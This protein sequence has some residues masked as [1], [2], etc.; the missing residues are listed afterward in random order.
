MLI[1]ATRSKARRNLLANAGFGYHLRFSI[2]NADET[3]RRKETP[4]AHVR[5]LA[6]AK[7]MAILPRRNAIIIGVDTIVVLGKEI[8]GKPKNVSDARRILRKLSGRW[9]TV[10]SGLAVRDMARRTMRVRV[11]KTRV[12][13][14]KLSHQR[15]EWYVKTGEPF[16]K[17]G[18]YAVQGKGVAFID[19]IRGSITNVIGLPM[20]ILERLLR[21]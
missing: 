16:G 6:R 5:R 15:I 14:A 2:S 20:D 4:I 13:F 21:T 10:V 12:K 1:L 17:A 8:I 3:L 18:A 19:A 11:V 9:H 7:T